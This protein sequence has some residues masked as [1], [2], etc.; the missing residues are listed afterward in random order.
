MAQYS[1]GTLSRSRSPRTRMPSLEF[2][3]L[4]WRVVLHLLSPRQYENN[5]H[6]RIVMHPHLYW[7]V[8]T[9]LA[10]RSDE[11]CGMSSHH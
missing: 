4:H 7:R 5:S 6:D 11:F 2:Y 8:S 3:A 9:S 1:V 10:T